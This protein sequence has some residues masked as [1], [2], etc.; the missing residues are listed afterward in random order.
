MI[1]QK[2]VIGDFR[3]LLNHSYRP[4]DVSP[5]HVLKRIVLPMCEDIAVLLEKGT[6]NDAWQTLEG[7]ATECRKAAL[8]ARRDS[9]S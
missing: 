7:F 3:V 6:R 2:D 5:S 4:Y 9:W 8:K 1:V